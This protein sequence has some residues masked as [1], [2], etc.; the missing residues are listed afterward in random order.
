MVLSNLAL[1][2]SIINIIPLILSFVI[3]V[4]SISDPTVSRLSFWMLLIPLFLYIMFAIGGG[5][6]TSINGVHDATDNTKLR[7]QYYFG[8]IFSWL[9]FVLSF[10][11]MFTGIATIKSIF[12]SLL[13]LASSIIYSLA[14]KY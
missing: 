14:S 1:S 3:L 13:L 6:E 9:G 7:W 4:K 8:L 2:S 12:L 11:L 10:V 5:I